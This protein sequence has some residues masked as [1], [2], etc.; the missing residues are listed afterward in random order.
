VIALV[1]DSNSMLPAWL[2]ERYEIRVVPLTVVVDGVPALEDEI[3]LPTFYAAL[4]SGA[5]VSTAA[6]APGQLLAA[7]EAAV[8]DGADEI[9]SVHLGSVYSTTVG[10][11]TLAASMLDAPVHVVDTNASSFAA[12]LCVWRAAE[13]LAGGGCADAAARVAGATGAS[14][15]AMFTVAEVARAVA[16]GRIRVDPGA[17]GPGTPVLEMTG[18]DIT[19]IGQAATL[20]EAVTSMVERVGA[21]GPGRLRLGVGDAEAAEA[22]ALLA[23][24]LAQLENVAEVVRYV[25]G[26][27]VAA[28]TGAGT[29]GLVLHLLDG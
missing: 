10:A 9:V 23:A 15:R 2:V 8:V 26:P 20:D 6:P 5:T 1:A 14:V 17:N 27:S 12:G 3:D 22:G 11:A 7:Y 19:T 4:R 29:F 28:H 13:V 16:G 21:L 25:A 24:E 18:A